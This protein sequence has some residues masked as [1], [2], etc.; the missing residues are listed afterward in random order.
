M[1]MCGTLHKDYLSQIKYFPRNFPRFVFAVSRPF[2]SEFLGIS[3]K[4]HLTMESYCAGDCFTWLCGVSK[5]VDC[6][7]DTYEMHCAIGSEHWTSARCSFLLF[8]FTIWVT[9]GRNIASHKPNSMQR[10]K[11]CAEGRW[12]MER[13]LWDQ[14]RRQNLHESWESCTYTPP[15]PIGLCAVPGQLQALFL[16]PH[17]VLLS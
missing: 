16:V 17:S 15:I 13:R 1:R 8:F 12:C 3:A 11:W 14:S 5:F 10:M 4:S 7:A 9:H 2:R 6:Y